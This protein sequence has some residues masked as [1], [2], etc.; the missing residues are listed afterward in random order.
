MTADNRLWNIK[1]TQIPCNT[2]W[3]ADNNCQQYFTGVS[4]SVKS[5]NF[6]Q[7][8]A[9]NQW[10]VGTYDVCVRPEQGYCSI[11][12][13]GCQDMNVAPTT[14]AISTGPVFE[15]DTANVGD[16]GTDGCPAAAPRVF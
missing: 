6:D 12:W 14:G 16:T 4:G 15:T 10:L 1:V 11:C 5:F 8:D 3:T 9:A 13:E 2:A 7:L